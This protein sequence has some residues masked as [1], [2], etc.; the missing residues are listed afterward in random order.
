MAILYKSWQIIL[1]GSENI[2]L[3][4]KQR[5][6]AKNNVDILIYHIKKIDDTLLAVHHT[7]VRL[8][9]LFG[10]LAHEILLRF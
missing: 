3:E 4:A 2:F 9:V 6:Y 5:N 8:F 1:F 10:E 7:Y